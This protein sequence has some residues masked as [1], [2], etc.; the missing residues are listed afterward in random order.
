[1]NPQMDEVSILRAANGWIVRPRA[2]MRECTASREMYVARTPGELAQLLTDWATQQQEKT[3][4][5]R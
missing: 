5:N 1:M 4:G 3:N 2:D